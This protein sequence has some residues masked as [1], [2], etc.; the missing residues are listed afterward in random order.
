MFLKY[1]GLRKITKRI[2]KIT[3]KFPLIHR[4]LAKIFNLYIIYWIPIL[5]LHKKL[6]YSRK[7]DITK[8]LGL[9]SI[10]LIKSK[11]I[12]LTSRDNLIQSTKSIKVKEGGWCV[13]YKNAFDILDQNLFL[14]SYKGKSI[15]LKILINNKNKNSKKLSNAYGLRP[16]GKYADV[17]EILRVGNRLNQL[18][19]GP[20]IY[21]LINLEDKNGLRCFAYLVEN[22]EQR[23]KIN[24]NEINLFFRKI[25]S[26][27]WLKPTWSTTTLIDD[28]DIDK[29]N[30]NFIKDKNGFTKFIDFQSF[31]IIDENAYI[32][33]IVKD[34]GNTSF[35]ANRIFSKENYLYQV[36]PEVEDG[37]RD[38]LTRWKEFDKI[39]Q[40]IMV[41]LKGKIILDVGCNIG[42][43]CY[44]ALSRGA[45]FTY[46]ID[47][48]NISIKTKKILNALGVT[49]SEIFGLDLNSNLDLN[50]INN[51]F[52]NSVDILF[53]CSIDGHIGY[54][55]QIRDIPFKYILHEGHPNSS[56]DENVDNLLKHNWLNKKSYKILYKNYIEDGDSPSRPLLFASR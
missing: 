51:L 12:D 11:K 17:R 9:Q 10:N 27:P 6:R 8:I 4:F 52:L 46:G 56:I 15:G 20:K 38:T 39:F 13:Y 50:K 47:K 2:G 16:F 3:K 34:F 5:N 55:N 25:N 18:F 32:N 44:Y 53:Y 43:N 19:I 40:K 33:E 24:S 26:D 1:I 42:M 31:S 54:P 48:E 45:K 29:E 21:D 28:F 36:L 49:R 22:I 14:D 41:S 7:K 35:G 30:T 37:K 23:G